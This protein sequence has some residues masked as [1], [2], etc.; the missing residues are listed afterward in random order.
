MQRSIALGRDLLKLDELPYLTSTKLSGGLHVKPVGGQSRLRH[1]LKANAKARLRL[2]LILNSSGIASG[3]ADGQT[4]VVLAFNE[5][6]AAS[7]PTS[8]AAHIRPDVGNGDEH[9]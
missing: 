1:L 5:A 6:S 2:F 3:D 8:H 4:I 7:N 9:H